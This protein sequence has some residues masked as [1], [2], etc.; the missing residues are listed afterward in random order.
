MRRI[1]FTGTLTELVEGI[2]RVPGEAME[3]RR[4][5]G[6]Q[7]RARVRGCPWA[8]CELRPNASGDYGSLPRTEQ[9][10]RRVRDLR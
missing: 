5:R 10:A 7:L 6:A 9:K 8:H 1:L 4:R 2:E 3:W